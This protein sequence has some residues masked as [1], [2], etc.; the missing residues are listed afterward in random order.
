M[1]EEIQTQSDDL[2]QTNAATQSFSTQS[3]AIDGLAFTAPAPFYEGHSLSSA[4]A[5][6]LN[7]VFAENLRNNFRKKISDAKA[8]A[9]KDG[10]AF[11]GELVNA[12]ASEFTT[13]AQSYEFAGKRQTRTPTDPVEKETIKLAR[14]RL[15]EHFKQKN[16]DIK[17]LAEGQF[18][19]LV[20]DLIAR[21]P[22]IR[23]RAKERVA[24]MQ[25]LAADMTID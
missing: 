5:N 17:S 6:V 11:E 2:T 19:K 16:F 21:K 1:T 7:Q 10:V 18:D 15:R 22:E 8:K 14:D 24:I 4:E 25:S 12:L 9:Q 23:E 13:Y 20:T 3:I